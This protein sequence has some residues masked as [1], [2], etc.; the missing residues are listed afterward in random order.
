MRADIQ[1]VRE[2]LQNFRGSCVCGDIVIGGI[3]LEENIAHAAA[4]EEGLVAVA[5]KGVADRIGEFPGVH[6]TIMRLGGWEKKKK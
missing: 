3:A 6:E 5:L 4:D 1:A 2:E